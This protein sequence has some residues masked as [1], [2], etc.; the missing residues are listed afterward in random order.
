MTKPSSSESD[1]SPVT[2]S[3]FMNSLHRLFKIAIYYPTGHVILDKA[4]DRFMHLLNQ[5][6]G[7]TP[8]VNIRIFHNT[9]VL[10][11]VEMNS[12]E[13]FIK[14]FNALFSTLGI[15]AITISRH[16]SMAEAHDFIRK[17][18]AYKAKILGAK[19]FTQIHITDLPGS[20]EIEQKEFLARSGKSASGDDADSIDNL[21][22]FIESLSKYGLNETEIEQCRTLLDS[23]P[24]QLQNSNIDMGD[25]PSASWD[26]VANLLARAIK[27]GKAQDSQGKITS[28]AHANINAL[29]SILKK[30]ETETHDKKSRD[31]IN[32]L[33]S[34]I[35]KPLA[36]STDEDVPE[37]IIIRRT[38]PDKP[39]VSVSHIQ[40]FTTKQKLN[41]KILIKIPTSLQDNETLSILMQLAHFEQPLPSQIRMQQ[42]FRETLSAT[43]SEK[44]W[45]ILSKGLHLLAQKGREARLSATIRLLTDPIRRSPHGNTLFLFQQTLK[46]CNSTENVLFWPHVVNEMLIEGCSKDTVSYHNL[47]LFAARLPN[48]QMTAAL[49]SLRSLEAFQENKIASDVFHS[50]S[51]ACY[52]LFAFL[53]K[54]EIERYIGERVLGGLR[55]N[56]RDWLIKAVVPLLDLSRQEDK[57]F[58]Y[59]Y[60]RQAAQKRLSEPLKNTAGAIITASLPHINQERRNET[61]VLDTIHA[62]A[63]LK[64]EK[65][66]ELLR[67]IAGGKKLLFIPEWPA[68]CRTAA[69]KALAASGH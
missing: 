25:L 68:A 37:E 18:L 39:T 33:V 48:E 56:P 60:L 32:L 3:E 4:T 61:W 7:D 35:R 24:Q 16:I 43:L 23:L 58:L 53:L 51:P 59:S 9:V 28:S 11:D 62:M 30:L 69:Q 10:E 36:D 40:E 44:T 17:M 65:T 6:A 54:T 14:E 13:P 63:Q 2:L 38:F 66:T 52:P 42:L 8:S 55:R 20:I 31:A 34:I 67:Q 15:S 49:S 41:P 1:T 26:D 22:T 46:L 47:C 45:E 50:V 64:S 5:L 12:E 19:Q 57:L 21:N 27:G 29:A